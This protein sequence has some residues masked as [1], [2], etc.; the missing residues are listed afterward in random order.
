M[1]IL[2][3]VLRPDRSYSIQKVKP[4]SDY[5][6]SDWRTTMLNPDTVWERDDKRWF[7]LRRWRSR[8]IFVMEGEPKPLAFMHEFET[9]CPECEKEIEVKGFGQSEMSDKMLYANINEKHSV[10]MLR[11]G[12]PWHWAAIVGLI[13]IVAL[14]AFQLYPVG[15]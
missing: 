11:P 12:F 14:L 9:V 6:E 7:G 1:K 5:V 2:K 8:S 3:Y 10:A 15:A 13:L 4:K